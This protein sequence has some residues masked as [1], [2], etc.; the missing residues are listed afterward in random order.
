MRIESM[1]WQTCVRSNVQLQVS[2]VAKLEKAT[3]V[4]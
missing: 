2:V 3:E 1:M 4:P